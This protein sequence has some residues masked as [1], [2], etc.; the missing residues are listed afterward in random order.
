MSLL[1]S[2]P[3]HPQLYPHE[4]RGY[5]TWG[6]LHAVSGHSDVDQRVLWKKNKTMKMFLLFVLD[7][8]QFYHD[9][10]RWGLFTNA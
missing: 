9:L 2:S 7:I 5:K 1:F 3:H 10:S 4:P 6:R 8:L